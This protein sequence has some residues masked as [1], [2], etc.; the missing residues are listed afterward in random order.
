MLCRHIILESLLG[1]LQDM[2]DHFFKS[3]LPACLYEAP[4]TRVNFINRFASTLS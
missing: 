2:L 3:G 4:R 1:A